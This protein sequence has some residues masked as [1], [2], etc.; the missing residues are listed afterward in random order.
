MDLFMFE[1]QTIANLSFGIAAFPFAWQIAFW[2]QKTPET[3]SEGRAFQWLCT[4]Q[5]RPW[6]TV[7]YQNFSQ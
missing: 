4:E 6:D 5:Y 1:A 7:S 2:V 3:Q